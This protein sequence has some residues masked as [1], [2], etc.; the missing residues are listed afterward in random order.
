MTMPSTE[1]AERSAPW[2]ASRQPAITGL[3]NT[4]SRFDADA[5]HKAAGTLP[6]A[7]DVKAIGA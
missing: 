1:R 4:P 2:L 7:T 6:P 5:L 3:R